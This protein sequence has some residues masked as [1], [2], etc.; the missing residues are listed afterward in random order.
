M[1]KSDRKRLR[2]KC[3][4]EGCPF[5]LL[6]YEDYTTPGAS[7]KT[8]VDRIETHLIA[9]D[10]NVIDY[11]TIALYSKK[12]IQNDPKYKVKDMKDDLHSVFDLNVSEA[13]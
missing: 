2:Y 5:L 9:Y 11:I 10:N 7:V 1:V 6:I 3:G 12:K 13:K 4:V 8:L